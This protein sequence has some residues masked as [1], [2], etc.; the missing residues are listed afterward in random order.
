[1]QINRKISCAHRLEG[2]RLLKWPYFPELVHPIKIPRAFFRELKKIILKFAWKYKRPWVVQA[3]LKKNKAGSIMLS[4]FKLNNKAT[5][6]K[7]VSYWQKNGYTDQWNRIESP[8]I[9]SHTYVQLIYTK[10][11]KNIQW[12]KGSLFNKWC[13]K[14]WYIYAKEWEWLFSH[15][16]YK[17]KLNMDKRL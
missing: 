10:G 1:M 8:Q 2:L 11:G 17:N 4:H 6:I 9:N 5:V 15:T 14:N 12:G 7:T 16:I 3:I 13:W